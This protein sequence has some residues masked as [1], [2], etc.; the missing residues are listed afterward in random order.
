MPGRVKIIDTRASA[1][2]LCRVAYR[3]PDKIIFAMGTIQATTLSP[4]KNV[5]Q[6]RP[7]HSLESNIARV[8]EEVDFYHQ[9][10]SRCLFSCREEQRQ[11]IENLRQQVGR[12]RE[13]ELP[14]LRDSLQALIRHAAQEGSKPE[15]QTSE[16]QV[17]HY[18]YYI[19]GVFQTLKSEIQ[20]SFS[21]FNHVRIW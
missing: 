16:M 17:Q 13:R 15:I 2:D 3:I 18:L 14:A 12:L 21:A 7:A 4:L 5:L 6:P 11:A 1:G 9:L 8:A 20:R 10:L 19:E